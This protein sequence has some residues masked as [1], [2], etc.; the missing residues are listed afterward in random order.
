MLS[1]HIASKL[2]QRRSCGNHPTFRRPE[3][4]CPQQLCKRFR[5]PSLRKVGLLNSFGRQQ[6]N[7]RLEC[8]PRCSNVRRRF[9]QKHRLIATM[10]ILTHTNMVAMILLQTETVICAQRSRGR[11]MTSRCAMKERKLFKCQL[12]IFTGGTRCLKSTPSQG[13]PA[14]ND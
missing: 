8:N 6:F 4:A 14:K 3:L 12:H 11:C 2:T 5:R 10:P 7:F 13:G 9:P 1:L